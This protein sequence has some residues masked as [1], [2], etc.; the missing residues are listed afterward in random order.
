MYPTAMVTSG[1]FN[2]VLSCFEKKGGYSVHTRNILAFQ[3]VVSQCLLTDL[4]FS[5]TPFTWTNMR[6]GTANIKERLNRGTCN[7]DF[8][9]KFLHYLVIHLPRTK[10]DHHPILVK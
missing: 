3:N 7:Q 2:Q 1:D 4:G 5:G 6:A 9:L 8:L 10:F